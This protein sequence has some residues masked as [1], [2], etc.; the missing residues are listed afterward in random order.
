MLA[1]CRPL[2]EFRLFADDNPTANFS[3][4]IRNGAVLD[5]SHV[6]LETVQLAASAF[7]LRKVYKDMFR[8]GET[9]WLRLALVLDEAHR[10]AKDITLPKI[11]KEGRKFGVAVVV[12]SQGLTDFHQDVLGNAGSKIVFRTNFPMSK[13][14]AGFLRP[15]KG[16]D[17]RKRD[18]AARRRR[19][20]RADP[21]M[22]RCA[23]SE[24]DPTPIEASQQ[25]CAHCRRY[26]AGRVVATFS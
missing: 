17:S 3:D 5:V 11:M 13:K 9:D 2:L 18:R 20:V 6:G 26:S 25:P 24:N 21:E 14:V 12:A 1:R 8:W 23:Q 15:D 10:L 7:V 16:V 4:M 22:G 19:G